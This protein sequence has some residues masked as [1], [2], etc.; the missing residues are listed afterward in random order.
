M[1]RSLVYLS[2][3]VVPNGLM[4]V[5]VGQNPIIGVV[6]PRL[7]LVH[8]DVTVLYYNLSAKLTHVNTNLVLPPTWNPTHQQSPAL[9]T[10]RRP[11][12]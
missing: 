9:S 3:V 8:G 4:K 5:L 7:T 1:G 12:H 10:P 2:S 11:S 6:T